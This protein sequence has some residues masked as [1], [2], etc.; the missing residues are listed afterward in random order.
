MSCGSR[1]LPAMSDRGDIA[2]LI[3]AGGRSSRFGS[4]KAMALLGGQSLLEITAARLAPQVRKL[5]VSSHT[6]NHHLPDVPLLADPIPERGPLGG[7]LA[8]LEWLEKSEMALLVSTPVDTP[9][10]PVN[11]VERLAG[12]ARQDRAVICS[13][14]GRLQPAFALWPLSVLPILPGGNQDRA[15][16]PERV[17]PRSGESRYCR[18][19]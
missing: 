7:I 10:F 2:G 1:G 13:Q 4:D 18:F 3:L 14:D 12:A 11:L 8:G 15:S 5:A 19:P 9:F 16:Q 17:C 6:Q